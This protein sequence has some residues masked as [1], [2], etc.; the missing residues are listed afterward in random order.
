MSDGCVCWF[1]CSLV[2]LKF[3]CMCMYVFV[4]VHVHVCGIPGSD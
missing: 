3:L 1:V 2:C 4:R